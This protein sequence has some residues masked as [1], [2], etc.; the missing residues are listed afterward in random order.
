MPKGSSK[1]HCHPLKKKLM[2]LQCSIAD[3]QKIE[4]ERRLSPW[5]CTKESTAQKTSSNFLSEL[6]QAHQ[7]DTDQRQPH[8][9][10]LKGLTRHSKSTTRFAA[11]QFRLKDKALYSPQRLSRKQALQSAFVFP[12]CSNKAEVR[13]QIVH[14][15]SKNGPTSAVTFQTW[16]SL[17]HSLSS[18]HQQAS[19]TKKTVEVLSLS[20]L[21]DPKWSRRISL[22]P[23]TA[24]S[25][26]PPVI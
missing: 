4:L 8:K 21:V 16:H 2:D 15:D 3:V 25:T 12:S 9:S 6:C 20:P 5:W 13:V 7:R 17:N 24:I 26:S 19:S 23:H 11:T 22:P 10:S 18:Y 14:M 1:I